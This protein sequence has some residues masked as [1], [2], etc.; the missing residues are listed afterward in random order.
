MDKVMQSS[1]PELEY[2]PKKKPTRRDRFLAELEAITPWVALEQTLSPFYPSDGRPGR[3]PK[4]LS[5]MLRM[6]IVRQCFGFSDEGTEDAIYDSQAVRRFIGID[7]NRDAAP[8]A[9][10]LLHFRHRLEQHQ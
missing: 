4:G 2:A 3:P 7:L 5:R 9:A 8:D 1:F 6:Y 10:T